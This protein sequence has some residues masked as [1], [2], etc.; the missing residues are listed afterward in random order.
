MSTTATRSRNLWL[1]P[2]VK[3]ESWKPDGLTFRADICHWAIDRYAADHHH[4]MWTPD[5][6]VWNGQKLIDAPAPELKDLSVT[7]Y[8]DDT[9]D[10]NAWFGFSTEYVEPHRVDLD[11]AE[12]M[13][14]TLRRLRRDLDRQRDTYGYTADL[15]AYVARVVVALKLDGI[16]VRHPDGGIF[17]TGEPYRFMTGADSF[18]YW[19]DD[20]VK[21]VSDRR[22]N[23]TS[24]IRQE[25]SS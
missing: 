9:G 1:I 22:H 24:A 16:A 13:A 17:P 21:A 19:L 18:R 15:P 2:T 6:D 25:I 11:R 23:S 7:A 8:L 5:H 14:K 12:S 3:R 20:Q 4:V 10:E